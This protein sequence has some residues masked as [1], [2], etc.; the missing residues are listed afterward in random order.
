MRRGRSFPL[1]WQAPT[2]IYVVGG[3][4]SWSLFIK[5]MTSRPDWTAAKLARES[6]IARSTIFRWMAEGAEGI[7]IESVFRVA[8]ALGVS[9]SEALRAASNLAPDADPEVDLIRASDRSDA[10]KAQMIDRLMTRREE[11]S[12][13]RIADLEW[14][15][16]QG[17]EAAG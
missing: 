16:S 12:A 5:R 11:E 4:D 3:G 13:R 14:M 15:L 10:V 9:R 1:R 8:D 2:V 7:T 17:D 6:G